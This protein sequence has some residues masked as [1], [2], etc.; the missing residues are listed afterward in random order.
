MHLLLQNYYLVVHYI[1]INIEI[2]LGDQIGL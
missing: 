2:N 1:G